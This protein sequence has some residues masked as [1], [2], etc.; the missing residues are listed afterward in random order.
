[1]RHATK[2][3]CVT[4]EHSATRARFPTGD[5]AP[6]VKHDRGEDR[7]TRVAQVSSC[8]RSEARRS[9]NCPTSCRW[10]RR[11]TLDDCDCC[12]AWRNCWRIS[13]VVASVDVLLVE[14]VGR[15]RIRRAVVRRRT[16]RRAACTTG[17]ARPDPDLLGEGGLKHVLQ[18]LGLV[19]GQRPVR[20]LV[21]DEVVDLRL[22]LVLGGTRAARLVAR[23]ALLRARCRCRSAPSRAPTGPTTRSCRAETSDCNSCCSRCSGDWWLPAEAAEIEVMMAPWILRGFRQRPPPR[24]G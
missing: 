14:S 20:H 6:W 19:R 3:S 8:S 13:A 17:A 23:P 9:P 10:R 24:Y 4:Q 11:T 7:A 5:H 18:L 15:R 12:S 16:G 2:C 21:G 1:M 22:H